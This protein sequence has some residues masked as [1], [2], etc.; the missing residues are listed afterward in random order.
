MNGGTVLRV[1]TLNGEPVFES[2]NVERWTGFESLNGERWTG[3]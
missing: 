1:R 3:F 2:V